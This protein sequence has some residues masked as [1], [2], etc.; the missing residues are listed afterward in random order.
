MKKLIVVAIVVI[1]IAGSIIGANIAKGA[2]TPAP[3]PNVVLMNPISKSDAKNTKLTLMGSGFAPKIQINLVLETPD[4]SNTDLTWYTMPIDPKG[5]VAAEIK[6]NEMGTFAAVVDA[7]TFVN[8]KTIGPGLFTID[9]MDVDYNLLAT[10]PFGLYD[11]AKPETWP[12]WVAANVPAPP[13][14]PSP[15]PAK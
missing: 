7:S 14:A 12:T 3:L 10:V 9:V 4:G 1:A 13:P 8:K 2:S 15:A 6:T 5:I 11:P